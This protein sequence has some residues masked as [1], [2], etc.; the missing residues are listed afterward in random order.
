MKFL[1]VMRLFLILAV[2]GG[3][4]RPVTAQPVPHLTTR[5]PGGLP[6]VPVMG[7]AGKLTN[8]LQLTWDGPSGAYQ[9]F[10][11]SNSLNAPWMALGGATNLN[12]TATITKL[13]N[14]AFFRVAGP[15]P[16][17]GGERICQSCH[18]G[19][20]QYETNTLHTGA[21]TDSAFKALGG[22]TNA[23]CLPCHTVGYGV[24]TGFT[25]TNRAGTLVYTTNL[26]GVQCENCH[27]PAAN[28]AGSENNP[29]L[30]PR[31]E[32]AATLCGGC[33]QASH[34]TYRNAPT[35][36][37]WSASGHAVVVPEALSRMA[38]ATTNLRSCGVCHSGSARLALINGEDPALSLTND[39]NVPVT[40]VVCHDPHQTNAVSP[41]QLRQPLASTNAF[42][43]ADAD[44][45]SLTAFTRA[46]Q[47]GTNINL[48]AQCHNDRGAS[49]TDT[50]RAPHGSL[51]YN[52]LLGSVGELAGGTATFN[53]GAHSGLP[54]SAANSYS[55]TFYLT[56]QCVDCHMQA[57]ATPPGK[58]S[59]TFLPAYAATNTVCWNCHNPQASL[60]SLT[61]NLTNQVAELIFDLN[62][63]AALKAPAMLR[64][65][66]VVA[67]EY[68]TPGGLTWQTN[69]SG[70]VT[71][72]S[73]TVPP[74][75]SGPDAAGQAWML[76]NAPNILKARY[77][78]Y[79]V[80]NDGSFG[81]HNPAFAQELLLAAESWLY[82]E[83]Y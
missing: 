63:W 79:L 66:G 62:R 40:C 11:K 41:A 67:W 44:T 32:V 52:F 10:Q 9:V 28:H 29:A 25:L 58:P 38:G 42:H 64:S 37:E 71:S 7:T 43:L 55:H 27:G 75:F 68:T 4:A 21:F 61:A 22:Q 15:A 1:S 60:A 34:T 81:V 16:N 18:S 45:V 54:A 72:W 59:H 53:P 13:Y 23:S 14:T 73:Q 17:Y 48:C 70:Y 5:Q 56:N 2:A 65:N 8:G 80:L 39:F 77:D 47:A 30:W 83:L 20:C 46:Y 31:V 78:L 26:A 3:L 57:D 49:W 51:Q 19:I 76:T 33:H 6:G 35:Y 82:Q 69:A 24:P 12:G 36:E 74:A 50:A